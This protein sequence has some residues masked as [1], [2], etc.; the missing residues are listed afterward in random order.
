MPY[1]C[2][3]A[4]IQLN[5][6]VIKAFQL[7][8]EMHFRQTMI[9]R[10]GER[11]FLFRVTSMGADTRFTSEQKES[12]QKSL[13]Q[14]SCLSRI[15]RLAEVREIITRYINVTTTGSESASHPL[16]QVSVSASVEISINIV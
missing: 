12:G 13:L 16:L 7:Q 11:S 10:G 9:S 4:C 2:Q 5:R 1:S 8:Q 15:S 6:L 14:D 3:S